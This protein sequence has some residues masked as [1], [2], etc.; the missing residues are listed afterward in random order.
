[1]PPR[2]SGEEWGE[3]F[4]D[5]FRHGRT[6]AAVFLLK[7]GP[8]DHSLTMKSCHKIGSI[9]GTEDFDLAASPSDKLAQTPYK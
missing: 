9:V 6:N 7:L 3:C 5:T 1:M 2:S 4:T 8:V